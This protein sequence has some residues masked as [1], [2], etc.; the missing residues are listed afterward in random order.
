MK[1]LK[2]KEQIQNLGLYLIV[3]AE[4]RWGYIKCIG[5]LV[6]LKYYQLGLGLYGQIVFV[7]VPWRAK[8]REF[9]WKHITK[10]KQL[11][12]LLILETTTWAVVLAWTYDPAQ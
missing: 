12:N 6:I 9:L 10:F 1:T 3:A 5:L 7:F 4:V 11:Q 2:M 8:A